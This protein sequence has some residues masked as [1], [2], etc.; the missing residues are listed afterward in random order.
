M[1]ALTVFTREAYERETHRNNAELLANNWIRTT[2]PVQAGG[3]LLVTYGWDFYLSAPR[4]HASTDL[5]AST[6][7]PRDLQ[8]GRRPPPN[9]ADES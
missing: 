5:H 2:K 8:S 4:R 3:E 1:E 6:R 7:V 9:T